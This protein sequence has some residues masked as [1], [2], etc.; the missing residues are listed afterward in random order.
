MSLIQRDRSEGQLFAEG[1]LSDIMRVW[2]EQLD[3]EVESID[4]DTL[5]ATEPSAWVEHLVSRFKRNAP[6]LR[7]DEVFQSSPQ[8]ADI[9]VSHDIRFGRRL[10]GRPSTTRGTRVS[11]HVPHNGETDLFRYRP[12]RSNMSPMRAGVHP[13]ELTFTYLIT[14]GTS[15]HDVLR[16]FEHELGLIEDVAAAV[17]KD[18]AGW[19]AQLP[20][21]ARD[22]L[23]SR[24]HKL[25]ADHD[26]VAAFGFP[27]RKRVGAA[28]TFA[29][30]TS[31]RQILP[32]T[33]SPKAEVPPPEP[34]LDAATFDAILGVCRT[35]SLVMERSP[36]AF[37]GMGEEDLRTQFLVA[38]NAQFKGAASGETFNCEGKTDILIRHQDRNIFIAE[39]KFWKGPASLEG[40]VDQL[41]GYLAWRD[42]K[43]AILLFN[44]N[45]DFTSVVEQIGAVVRGHQNFL[46]EAARGG[47]T[48]FRAVL[49]QQGDSQRELHLV[50]LA[51]DVPV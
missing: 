4:A 35:M 1:H 9:D 22:L 21:A 45:K 49:H 27:V 17:A 10:D 26:L 18:V 44:R 33:T 29:V 16:E 24:R 23:D 38:L 34:A 47:E 50:V 48:E 37:A 30:P 32:P 20:D 51:F 2:S 3:D 12:S 5:L 14:Q 31:R 7:A 25:T 43:V 28:K 8:D 11:F 41:L 36:G 13:G 46:R 39:C 6:L 15:P 19:N 42:T 40:A